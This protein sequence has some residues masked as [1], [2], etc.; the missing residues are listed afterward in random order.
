M[1]TS[2]ATTDHEQAGGTYAT[3]EEARRLKGDA[4]SGHRYSL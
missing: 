3:V 1:L 2:S 4:Y